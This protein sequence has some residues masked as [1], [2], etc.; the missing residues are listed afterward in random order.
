[1]KYHQTLPARSIASLASTLAQ[2]ASARLMLSGSRGI[3]GVFTTV[4]GVT[5]LEMLDLEEDEEDDD[6]SDEGSEKMDDKDGSAMV[7][8]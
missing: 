3:G 1:M 8:S 6:E 2:T 4:D 7:L 5:T